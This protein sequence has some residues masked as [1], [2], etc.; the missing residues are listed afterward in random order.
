MFLMTQRNLVAAFALLALT[1]I[2]CIDGFSPAAHA[3]PPNGA[4]ATSSDNA[5]TTSQV[6]A[7]RRYEIL[8]RKPDGATTVAL[9]YVLFVPTT[10]SRTSNL[11]G[12]T[13]EK[14]YTISV[15]ETRTREVTIPAGKDID[16]FLNERYRSTG[17]PEAEV[18]EEVFYELLEI[19][20]DGTRIVQMQMTEFEM[21]IRTRT[22]T[23]N[24]KT[25]EQCYAAFV[26][27]SNEVVRVHVPPG[28]DIL[29]YLDEVYP[30]DD[31]PPVEAPVDALVEAPVDSPVEAP[32]DS[33][34]PIAPPSVPVVDPTD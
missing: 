19:K 33:P 21:E 1:A 24:G 18:E 3:Q 14:I 25:I 12:R 32:V 6:E 22:L 30:C 17:L 13:I 34:Q 5:S 20:S 26:P 2:G 7:K 4:V 8:G 10:L 9:E 11:N 27:V 23:K 28:R 31:C 15:P 29:D 16:S